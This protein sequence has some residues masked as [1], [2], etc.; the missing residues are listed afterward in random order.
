LSELRVLYGAEV[1]ETLHRM[2]SD[3]V[4]KVVFVA[5]FIKA[6]V[7]KTILENVSEEI[8]ITCL[9]R[10]RADEV[11]AGVSDLEI[12]EIIKEKNGNVYLLQ[13]LH[14]KYYRG[15]QV[16]FLG[17]SNLTQAALG[18]S[19]QSNQELMI[20]TE[21]NQEFSAYEEMLFCK[22]IPVDEEIY[23]LCKQR[24][25]EYLTAM[26][27]IIRNRRNLLGKCAETM[28]GTD[29]EWIPKSRHPDSLFLAYSGIQENLSSFA[30]GAA[31]ADLQHFDIPNGLNEKSFR[32]FIGM[33]LLQEPIIKRVDDAVV[34]E[35]R[36]GE[37]VQKLRQY[38]H[39]PSADMKALW[40][41]L[42]RWLLYFLPE[43]Y[44][45]KTYNYSEILER[46]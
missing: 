33:Q 2:C 10:W 11:A 25:A 18:W 8:E 7:M 32:A 23:Q 6:S 1:G 4:E 41:V 15:D 26:P 44:V 36:F 16:V 37:M 43:R 27:E 38:V 28:N 31:V 14:A 3:A 39:D 13:N 5:P 24:M 29:E 21:R 12:Y 35:Y 9:T 30:L 20:H 45:L 40:Q 19:N 34:S 17:S 42:I 46:R 22:A